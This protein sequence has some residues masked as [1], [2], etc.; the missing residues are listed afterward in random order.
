MSD[1]VLNIRLQQLEKNIA[2]ILHLLNE[3]EEELIDEDDPGK[4][5]KYRR[6]VERLNQQKLTYEKEFSELQVQ[7][8]GTQ[9][10]QVQSIANQLQ[11]I[12]EKV[13]LLLDSQINLHQALLPHF[14]ANERAALLPLATQLNENQI[15]E[16]SAVLEAVDSNQI[17]ELEIQSIINQTKVLLM[18][19]KEHNISLPEGDENII[20]L[21]NE[22]T[23]DTKHALKISVPII[24]FLV[25]YEG[26]VGLGTGL[27]LTEV[28]KKL[29]L[30]FGNR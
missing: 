26:E 10:H 22:P 21:I 19:L 15:I 24:P 6:R 23:L 14:N 16:I 30:K 7:V 13:D 25:S 18:Q 29:V 4:I 3:Y 1:S 9:S 2:N 5:S 11:Q 8:V 20:E 17:P 28:W 27:N 12:N